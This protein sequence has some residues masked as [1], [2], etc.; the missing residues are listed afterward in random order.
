MSVTCCWGG[1][2]MIGEKQIIGFKIEVFIEPDDDGFHAYCPALKGLHTY[3][4]TEEQALN[5]ARDA[6]EAYLESSIKHGDS[7]PVGVLLQKDVEANPHKNIRQ[8]NRHMEELQVACA[9]T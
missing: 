8:A 1:Y 7:I 5:N 4:D 9:I 2:M 3:G 6:A